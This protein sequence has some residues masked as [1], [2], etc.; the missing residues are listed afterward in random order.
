M[1]GFMGRILRVNLGSGKISEEPLPEREARLFLGGSGLATWYL[2]RE[3]SPGIDPLGPDNKLIFL[4]GPLTGT[5]SPS[6]GRFSA[7]AKSPQTGFWGSSNS[8][9]RFGLDFK[10]TGYDGVIIEGA[11]DAPVTLVVDDEGARLESAADLWGLKVP[12]AAARLK[13]KHG[14]KTNAALIG[15]AGE[16]L[17]RFAAIMNDVHRALGRCGLGAVMGSKKLKAVVAGGSRKINLADRTNFAAAAKTAR[18][19]VNESLLKMTLEVYGTNMVLDMV[20][21]K[22]GLP[23]RNWQSGSCGYTDDINGPAINEN[24]LVGRQACF[25][26]PIACGRLSEVKTGKYACRGEGPEYESVGAFGPMC[27]VRDLEAI[28][29]AHILCNEYGLDTVSTGAVIAFAM[30]CHEKGI[31]TR[32]DCDGLEVRFGDPDA[33][34]ELIHC[35]ARRQGVGDLLAEGSRRAAARLGQGSDRFAMQV[36]GLELPSYDCRATKITGLGFVT[37]NRGGDHITAYVQGPTFLDIP[38]LIVDESA[39]ADPMVENPAEAKV[40]KDLED[41]LTVFD[42]LGACKFMGMA[43]MAEDLVPVVAAAVGW[44]FS[45]EEFRRAGERI[46]NLARLYNIREGLTRKDDNLPE[47]LLRDP[48]PDGPAAGLVVDL[49]PLLDAY[50]RFRG[51][52][53]EGRPSPEKLKEL[54]LQD[55]A[56]SMGMIQ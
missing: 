28:T 6:S 39:I 51:W 37:S 53:P 17:V 14:A 25:A 9:G 40:V 36:K 27:D 16:N 55:L 21:V 31:L 8:G 54:G 46:F 22:G 45:V 52:D 30:E 20:N 42:S 44:D 41:A 50:Y 18:N 47:R 33:V 49:A 35:I 48:L 24:I 7:A 15:P 32:E 1:N 2:F 29:Y 13:E 3:T 12:E 34:I 19:F 11:A 26:C 10:K 56:R 5:P 38:F 43:L 4:T 23:T